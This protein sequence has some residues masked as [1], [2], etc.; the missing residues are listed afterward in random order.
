MGDFPHFCVSAIRDPS[1]KFHVSSRSVQVLGVLT[2]K[3]IRHPEVNAISKTR[4]HP[5]MVGDMS[6]V[7][8]EL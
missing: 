2:E 8:L 5:E 1:F 3:P 6:R 4:S 7:T